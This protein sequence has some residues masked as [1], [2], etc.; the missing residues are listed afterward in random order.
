[1]PGLDMT[2]AA[3]GKMEEAEERERDIGKEK[4]SEGGGGNVGE[5]KGPR[6]IWRSGR[7]CEVGQVQ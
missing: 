3:E 1:M 4:D 7:G 6:G 2:G 5:G